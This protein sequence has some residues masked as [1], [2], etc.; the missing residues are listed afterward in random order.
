MW[1]Y[2][3]LLSRF[4]RLVP[5]F[6]LATQCLNAPATGHEPGQNG[7]NSPNTQSDP[8]LRGGR[9]GSRGGSDAFEVFVSR[10]VPPCERV[11]SQLNLNHRID[12]GEV[13]G[14]FVP[15]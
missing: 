9:G 14:P 11:V 7:A 8:P 4:V 6:V 5:R 2:K 12:I 10:L 1:G 3:G 13:W 15:T